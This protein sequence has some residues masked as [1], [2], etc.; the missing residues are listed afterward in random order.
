MDTHTLGKI[1]R[2]VSE[3]LTT[4]IY[5]DGTVE[6]IKVILKSLL[7]LF[8]TG[9][10]G[11]TCYSFDSNYLAWE[12][13]GAGRYITFMLL[14]FVFYSIM[15]MLIEIGVIDQIRYKTSSSSAVGNETEENM[16]NGSGKDEDDDVVHER[17]RL[18]SSAIT[19]LMETDALVIKNLSKSY[20][21]FHAVRGISVG[22]PKCECF[23]L[24]GQNGAGKTTTFKMLTGDVR[25]SRGNAYLDSHDI[26][27]HLKEVICC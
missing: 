9:C 16:I 27:T 1:D 6:I 22:V 14:Q 11:S 20:G 25:V 26:K 23:G 17:K 15:V 3:P 7:T 13:P 12:K 10:T 8:I 21:S 4:R 19:S 24:L 2:F 18:N 5:V